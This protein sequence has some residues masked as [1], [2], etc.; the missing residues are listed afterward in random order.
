VNLMAKKIFLSPSDQT[1]NAYAYGNTTEAIQCGKVA[2]AL[3]AALER[4]GFEVKLMHYYTMANKVAASKSWGA[5]LYIPIHSNAHDGSVSGTRLFC[6]DFD[7]E[8]YKACKAVFKYLAPITPGKSENIKEY[9]GL[10][11][12]KYPSAP[13]VYVETDFHDN[14][15]AA[16]WLVENV[17]AI[18]EAIC[19]GVCEYFGYTY[20]AVEV[21][22]EAVEEDVPDVLYH[23]Q[24][25]AF[26]SKA[27]AEALKAKLEEDGY[28]TFMKTEK[29]N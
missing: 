7:G 29:I 28:D 27:N 11:E 17:E 9:P 10:Y 3:K 15:N 8:G 23:V 14:Y 20:K 22:E 5:D 25:G 12:V 16:K 4:C 21:K 1:R 13:T 19:K 24:V 6:Y 18:A 26:R 2:T